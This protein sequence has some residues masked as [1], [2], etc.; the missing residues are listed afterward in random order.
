MKLMPSCSETAEL[1][2]QGRDQDLAW[3]QRMGVRVHLVMCALCRRYERHLEFLGILSATAG[4]L[5]ASDHAHSGDCLSP[6]CKERI[7]ARLSQG[8]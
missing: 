5:S 4:E 3:H 1:I 2:S 8:A 7:K 6:D